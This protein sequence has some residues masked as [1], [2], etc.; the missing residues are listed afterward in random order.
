M[1]NGVDVKAILSDARVA[2]AFYQ[3]VFGVDIKAPPWLTRGIR[4]PAL[5]P[6][7]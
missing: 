3:A 2:D 5:S 4:C 6:G 7:I 1:L